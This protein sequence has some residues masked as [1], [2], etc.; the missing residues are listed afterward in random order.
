IADLT[1]AMIQAN[2]SNPHT[3]YEMALA[4]NRLADAHVPTGDI[5]K[6]LALSTEWV[7]SLLMLMAAPQELR[8]R[9]AA[10]ALTVTLA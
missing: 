8:E 9:V 4:C 1:V 6:R 5:A 2:M 10:E 7:K 3:A